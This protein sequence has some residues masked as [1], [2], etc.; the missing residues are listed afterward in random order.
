MQ[1]LLCLVPFFFLSSIYAQEDSIPVFERRED[2]LSVFFEFGS[3]AIDYAT[4]ATLMALADRW[5][6]ESN[7]VVMVRAHTDSVGQSEYNQ[8]LSADRAGAVRDRL[9]AHG[10]SGIKMEVRA[11]GGSQP[12]ASN[13]DA[14]GR[15]LNRRADIIIFRTSQGMRLRGSLVDGS[16]GQGVP[17]QVTA[18]SQ[19][20]TSMP[21]PTRAD[22]S[23]E[24]V[25]PKGEV[26][27]L[28]LSA[29]GY[30]Y[31]TKMMRIGPAEVLE[32]LNIPMPPVVSG[33]VFEM[34]DMLFVGGQAVLLEQSKPQLSRLLR[35]MQENP[36]IRI[37]IAGHVNVP[38]TPKIATS[39]PEYRLSVARAKMV[40][41]YLIEHGISAK[42]ME[43]NGYGNWEMKYPKAVAEK[44]QQKNRRVEI[45]IL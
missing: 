21:A 41:D 26:I 5:K 6:T 33:A 32:P 34:Q 14:E 28:E 8:K 13:S 4:D 37:E 3:F 20:G 43:Y 2:S 42:R 30:F 1:S 29:P 9:Q 19:F 25:V 17:G 11:L 12:K 18:S 7:F 44:Y 22:G 45:R 35:F 10:L 23:F 15:K 36:A 38:D 24:I 31:L 16:T 27:K 40:L 39:S